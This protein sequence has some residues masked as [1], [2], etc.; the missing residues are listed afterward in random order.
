MIGKITNHSRF[1]L[2]EPMFNSVNP[3][4]MWLQFYDCGFHNMS[5]SWING[6]SPAMKFDKDRIP[7]LKADWTIS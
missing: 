7:K 3:H 2:I 6:I 5:V 4:D 1:T